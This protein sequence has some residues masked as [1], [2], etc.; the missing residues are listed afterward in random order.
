M[1]GECGFFKWYDDKLCNRANE[2]IRELCDS[3]RILAKETLRLR[4][5]IM[6]CRTL[7]GG[8][9]SNVE[10]SKSGSVQIVG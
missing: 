2:V 6:K 9:S 3:E 10:M 5:Q 4:K 7:C 1:V 8:K